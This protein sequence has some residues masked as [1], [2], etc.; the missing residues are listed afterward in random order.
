MTGEAAH[1]AG[2]DLACIRGERLL[3]EH[4]SFALGP[5]EALMLTGAN[6]SGKTSFLRLVA[7]LLRPAAG[8]ILWR[9]RAIGDDIE[10][11]HSA[12]HFAGHLDAVKP[13]LTVAENVGFWSRLRAGD[14]AQ[15]PTALA[16]FGLAALAEMPARFLSAGQ[17]RRVGLARLLAAPAALWL[18]D[19]PTVSLD[20]GA[21]AALETAIADHRRQGGLVIAA[22][23][24]ALALPDAQTLAFG[25]DVSP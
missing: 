6:G 8:R 13:V 1:S 22:T 20:S 14:G 9:G 23:H 19:E 16:H 5:G 11:Y 12:V 4:L 10:A 7:G 18:L 24:A 3:F 21:V 25:T 15:V 17:R 2:E